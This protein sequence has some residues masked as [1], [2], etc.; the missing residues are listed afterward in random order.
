MLLA[1]SFAAIYH[2]LELER[3][4]VGSL[5][6]SEAVRLVGAWLVEKGCHERVCAEYSTFLAAPCGA[7]VVAE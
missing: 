7:F 5:A 4:F 6:T 1:V 3:H 2:A